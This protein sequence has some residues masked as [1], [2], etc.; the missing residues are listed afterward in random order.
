MILSWPNNLGVLGVIGWQ[1]YFPR[2]SNML[3]CFMT[4]ERHDDLWNLRHIYLYI[5][6]YVIVVVCRD[7]RN[8][9]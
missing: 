3:I 2:F 1:R 7:L 6:N 5:Y 8:E 4:V 9:I